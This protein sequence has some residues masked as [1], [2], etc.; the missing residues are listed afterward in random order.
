MSDCWITTDG[1]AGNVRQAMALAQALG[2]ASPRQWDL[3]ALAPWR[4]LAPR[5]LPLAQHAFGKAFAQALAQPP[6]FVIGCGRQGA[7]ASRLFRAT[8]SKAVQILDPR[9]DSRHWDAVIAPAHDALTG[10]NVISPLCS[11]HPVDAAWLATARL[12]HPDLGALPGPRTA[13]LLGGPIATAALD[14]NWWHG[15]LALLDRLRAADGSVLVSTSRRTPAWL[16]TAAK[17]MLPQTP[18]LRWL[19]EG[20]G[21]NPYPGLLAWADRIIVSPD[22]VNMISE[23]C[24]TEVPV[25]VPGMALAR[26]RHARFLHALHTRGR[27]RSDADDTTPW[28]ITPLIELPA[29]AQQVRACLT[30]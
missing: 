19:N 6:A 5:R 30:Q 15:V 10:N 1:A 17:A 7:L 14:G 11:L 29:I 2:F 4:W 26:G 12:A 24:A 13:V 23:A 3:Q 27:I 9:I 16:R 25:W 18:G 8:G 22:S 21:N 20:D 28:P